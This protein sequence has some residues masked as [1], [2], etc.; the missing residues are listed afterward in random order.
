[1]CVISLHCAAAA[2]AQVH[3]PVKLNITQLNIIDRTNPFNRVCG[4]ESQAAAAAAEASAGAAACAASANSAACA[5][6]KA[7]AAA[8]A[9]PASAPLAA[10]EL[11]VLR[12]AGDVEVTIGQESY[13][14]ERKKANS[15]AKPSRLFVN[16]VNMGDDAKLTSQLSCGANVYLRYLIL[17]GQNS[18]KLWAAL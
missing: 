4:A 10:S 5:A 16:G 8:V 3:P 1:M 6:A 18:Q 9:S 12:G 15:D 14:A 2:V 13:L 7:S 17:P 11:Q